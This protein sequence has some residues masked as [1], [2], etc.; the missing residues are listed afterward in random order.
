MACYRPLRAYAPASGRNADGK[1][2]ISFKP[3]YGYSEILLP[4]GQC[5]GC[6][7]ERSRQWA[8]RCVHEAQ[9]YEHNCF[10][11][12][13]YDDE[14]LP[15]DGSL[16][17]RDI[18]LFLKRLRK[19]YGAGIR[20]Y[21]CG[22]YGE[23]LQR[24]HHHAILFNFDFPDKQLWSVRDGV[25]L[26]RSESLEQ[27]WPYGYSTIG[28]VTFESAAYVARYCTKKITGKVAGEHYEGKMPEYATMSR[29]PGIGRAWLEKYKDDVYN[30]DYVVLR[31]GLK[32]RPPRY[33]DEIYDNIER[34]RMV[35]IKEKRA[36]VAKR[37]NDENS[38]ERLQTK[39]EFQERR[40]KEI[41][42]RYE[43]S[44]LE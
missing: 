42:R 43:R 37:L 4:C 31:N 11:T 39:E 30:Y 38:W 15:K 29:R 10:V 14:H 44:E 5:I 34:E 20:F 40:W 41:A 18:T 25:R 3:R 9:M 28:D 35:A 8:M 23:L 2:D 21:Q 17:K 26:Y 33:Y 22:E 1:L 32:L 7:L 6:R 27:L 12:L 24:P 13:T 19:R 36:E 16:N